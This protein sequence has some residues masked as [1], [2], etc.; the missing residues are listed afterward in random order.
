MLLQVCRMPDTSALLP[1]SR[2]ELVRGTS[3][4]QIGGHSQSAMAVPL[5]LADAPPAQ[6]A[7]SLCDLLQGDFD[8]LDQTRAGD[9]LQLPSI[10]LQVPDVTSK[11]NAELRGVF[12]FSKPPQANS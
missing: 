1:A 9:R 10:R 7:E 2:I 8:R 6:L 4:G 11:Q 3:A 5:Y 12:K